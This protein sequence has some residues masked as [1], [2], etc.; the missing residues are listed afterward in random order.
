MQVNLNEDPKL[1][2]QVEKM[3]DELNVFCQQNTIEHNEALLYL[4][5]QVLIWCETKIVLDNDNV[6]H[7]HIDQMTEKF[8]LGLNLIVNKH[9]ERIEKYTLLTK[10]ISNI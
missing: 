2:P 9:L 7:E 8:K 3:F 10:N 5:Q 1:K 4:T 6:Q